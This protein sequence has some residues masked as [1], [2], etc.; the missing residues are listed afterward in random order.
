MIGVACAPA[1]AARRAERLE[2]GV[3]GRRPGDVVD[4]P[5]ALQPA[6]GR[7]VVVAE[8]R[9]A[10]G[11]A[12]LPVAPVVGVVAAEP[13]RGEQ[14]GA[15]LGQRGVRA[16]AVEALERV[17]V[18]D[19]GRMGGE[20]RVVP[21]RD[22]QLVGE[23]LGVAE[24]QDVAVARARDARVGEARLPERDRGRARRRASGSR[25]P[26]RRPRGRGRRRGTRRT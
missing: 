12:E 14:R 25:G 19:V 23:A 8:A 5:G 26:S 16:H 4:R 22:E 9:M 6:V 21:A 13:E 20:R 7:R 15:A 24:Q 2:L 10:V 11:A 3:V 1:S 17:L 18:G